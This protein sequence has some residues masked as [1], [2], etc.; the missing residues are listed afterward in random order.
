[1]AQPLEG[2]TI[3]PDENNMQSW[4]VVIRGPVSSHLPGMW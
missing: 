3:T 1:M 4:E 2:I